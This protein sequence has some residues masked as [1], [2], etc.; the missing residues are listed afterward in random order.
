MTTSNKKSTALVENNNSKSNATVQ[1]VQN[2]INGQWVPSTGKETV[3]IV[4][5][6]NKKLIEK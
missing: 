4:N 6:A 2:Y 3:D 1:I 5:P